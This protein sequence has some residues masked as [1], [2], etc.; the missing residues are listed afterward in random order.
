MPPFPPCTDISTATDNKV[1]YSCRLFWCDAIVVWANSRGL[2]KG[3]RGHLKCHTAAVAEA[4]EFPFRRDDSLSLL[5]RTVAEHM[6]ST[7]GDIKCKS[8]SSSLL[9]WD[10]F[11]PC[12]AL[13]SCTPAFV[14]CFQCGKNVNLESLNV[15]PEAVKLFFVHFHS[16][17]FQHNRGVESTQKSSV[18][19]I[20][21]I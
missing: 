18:I 8:P 15:F 5:L 1:W 2:Y 14:L 16:H 11:S 10:L 19:N 6:C 12:P 3:K 20:F 9:M 4:Q 17:L 13:P 7:E 21:R